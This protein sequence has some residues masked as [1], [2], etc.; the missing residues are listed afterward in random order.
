MIKEPLENQRELL[1]NKKKYVKIKSI[2][3]VNE[4]IVQKIEQGNK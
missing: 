2:K 4:K 3:S 1:K